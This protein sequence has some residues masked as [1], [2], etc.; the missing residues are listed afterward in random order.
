LGSSPARPELNGC[1][2]NG[3]RQME[4][5]MKNFQEAVKAALASKKGVA[6][7][8]TALLTENLEAIKEAISNRVQVSFVLDVKQPFDEEDAVNL[9]TR[10]DEAGAKEA[11]IR[12][13]KKVGTAFAQLGGPIGLVFMDGERV[14]DP[15]NRQA[16]YMAVIM[17][18]LVGLFVY[19]FKKAGG[20]DAVP[21]ATNPSIPVQGMTEEHTLIEF[22][23]ARTQAFMLV[24]NSPNLNVEEH[25]PVVTTALLEGCVVVLEGGVPVIH[26][27]LVPTPEE[28]AQHRAFGKVAKE[29][30]VIL[31][32]PKS[33]KLPKGAVVVPADDAGRNRAERRA[34]A[35][36]ARA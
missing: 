6:I 9:K 2:G 11:M 17:N 34:A 18:P 16:D 36:M 19:G 5:V 3:P 8:E 27:H 25:M 20:E 26:G 24:E 31:M 32:C 28:M 10:F 21:L 30:F 14:L 29:G 23:A 7:T 13:G 4:C 12:K 1:T 33:V 35:H 22:V 15:G